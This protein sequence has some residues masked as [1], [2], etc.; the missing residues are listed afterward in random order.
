MIEREEAYSKAT[1][2][3]QMGVYVPAEVDKEDLEDISKHVHSP[4]R[5]DTTEEKCLKTINR[6]YKLND[7]EKKR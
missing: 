3:Y 4:F 7:E 5:Q 6:W 1:M 2:K